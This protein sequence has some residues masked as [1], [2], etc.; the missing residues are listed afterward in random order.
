M[1]KI[2]HQV[3]VEPDSINEA[4]NQAEIYRIRYI[5]LAK[6]IAGLFLG[7]ICFILTCTTSLTGAP[8]LVVGATLAN[9]I[10][11]LI[12]EHIIHRL[13]VYFNLYTETKSKNP[14]YRN[15]KTLASLG[16]SVGVLL[17]MML[18]FYMDTKLNV[19]VYSASAGFMLGL[20]AFIFRYY[21]Q[22]MPTVSEDRKNLNARAGQACRYLVINSGTSK[23]PE[24]TRQ[25]DNYAFGA[26]AVLRPFIF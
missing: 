20:F 13:C 25:R 21:R 4:N 15:F 12:G 19:S 14:L 11:L 26:L 5:E 16:S 24:F 9:L 17:A 22:S 6:A 1:A 7:S 18:P 2:E 10:A 23:S 3:L 8:L